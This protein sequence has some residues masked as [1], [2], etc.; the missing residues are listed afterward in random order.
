[1]MAAAFQNV[2]ESYGLVREAAEYVLAV[3]GPSLLNETIFCGTRSLKDTD[4]VATLGL[5]LIPSRTIAVPGIAKAIANVELVKETLVH[6]G[7]H[8][9]LIGR[10][11]RFGVNR[12]K[13]ELPLLSIGP[14]TAGYRLLVHKGIHRIATVELAR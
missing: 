3:P 10:V 12:A 6:T 2:A 11:T 13:K 4:K 1:M 5:A 7:D 9:M 14:D 8:V